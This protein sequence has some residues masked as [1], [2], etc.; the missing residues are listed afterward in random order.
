MM[1]IDMHTHVG[2][3]RT[4]TTMDRT[5]ITFESLIARLDDEGIDKAVLLPMGVNAEGVFFGSIFDR[6]PDTVSQI[7]EGMQHT[8]RLILFGNVD[9]RAGGNLATTDFSWV[10]E[11]FVA[12]GCVGIG[13]VTANLESDDARVVNFF[14]QCGA[15]HFPVTIHGF[16]IGAGSYGLTDVPGSPHL[17]RLLQQVPETIV[18]GH[19]QGFWSEI[20]AGLSI[21]D[22]AGYPRGPIVEEG[23]LWRLMRTYPNLHCDMSAGSGHNAL[24]RDPA[25]GVRFINEFQDRIVFATDVCFSDERG[26]MPHLATLRR[27][28]AEGS[29]SQSVFD[30]LTYQNAL[31]ILVRYG[32]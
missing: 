14:R 9:P 27:L 13:E 11:R 6:W 12:M 17:E 32:K 30:K 19:G 23:S 26:R 5:P 31:R 25:Q 22:K 8:D 20:A 3:L 29:I 21:E 24:T 18:F 15:W 4:P 1:I 16:P 7:R 10:F 2:D 28:L